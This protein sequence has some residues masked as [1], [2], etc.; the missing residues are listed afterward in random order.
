MGFMKGDHWYEIILQELQ[1]FPILLNKWEEFDKAGKISEVRT[2]ENR[3]VYFNYHG[4]KFSM[5]YHAEVLPKYPRFMV[6]DYNPTNYLLKLL[7]KI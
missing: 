3:T 5:K 4:I 7:K 6:L 2:M 1:N